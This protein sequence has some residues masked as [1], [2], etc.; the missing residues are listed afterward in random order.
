MMFALLCFVS[1]QALIIAHDLTHANHEQTELCDVLN[2]FGAN[3][4]CIT[5][6]SLLLFASH[7][8]NHI[9]FWLLPI[10]NGSRVLNQRSRAPPHS[11]I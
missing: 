9:Y 6:Q 3:K 2:T 8:R 5:T 1:A 11:L 4:D 7:N 10:A